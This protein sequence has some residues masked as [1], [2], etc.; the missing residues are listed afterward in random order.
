MIRLGQIGLNYGLR[1]QI[2]AFLSDSRF[3][4]VG[5]CSANIDNAKKIK[6]LLNLDIAT[7]DPEELFSSVDAVSL[8]LPPR[9]QAIIL[10]KAIERGLHVFFEKPL[11]YIPQKNIKIKNSQA[12]MVDF[13]FL[14]I[15]VWKEARKLIKKN[16]IGDILH[17]EILWNSETN[18]VSKNLNSWK[19]GGVLNNFASHSL[20]Y[21]EQFM[22][23][24]TQVYVKPLPADSYDAKEKG[25]YIFLQFKSGASA[26]LCFSTNTYKGSGHFLEF[27]GSTGTILLKNNSKENLTSFSMEVFKKSGE[28]FI[29]NSNIP[30][31]KE[32]N[33]LIPLVESLVKRFGDCI[34]TG[35]T[36]NPGFLEALRVE[37][38]LRTC[39]KSINEGKEV[40]LNL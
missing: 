26:A 13:E 37:K 40:K 18:A 17:A 39:R 25:A 23:E 6:S 10:P 27:T 5:V 12:L 34:E 28:S 4:L 24:I 30:V 31:N 3:K 29:N 16:E 14:E 1:V 35:N 36:C 11:G 38:L 33:S 20:H 2:P 19:N 21:I 22:G 15:D 32:Q 7:D 9:E 8:A